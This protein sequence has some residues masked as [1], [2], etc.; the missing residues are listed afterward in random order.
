MG[1]TGTRFTWRGRRVALVARPVASTCSNALAAAESAFAAGIDPDAIASGLSRPVVVP[2]RFEIVDEGQP[3]GVIVDYAHT[4]DGLEQV[5]DAARRLR[6]GE[7]TVVFG[8]G[9]DRDATKRPGHGRGGGRLADRV[10]LTSDNPR[11]EDPEP[12]STP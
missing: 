9:G 1:A 12:S 11:G 2:G 6:G 4:P 8:C 3:F 10:V 5:L 7:V